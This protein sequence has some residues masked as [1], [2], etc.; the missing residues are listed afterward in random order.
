MGSAQGK[1]GLAELNEIGHT[2]L[3]GPLGPRY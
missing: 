1:G 2:D 3:E